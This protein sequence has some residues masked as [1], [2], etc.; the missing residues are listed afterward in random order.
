MVRSITHKTTT[1]TTSA[2]TSAATTTT[3]DPEY[4]LAFYMAPPQKVLLFVCLFCLNSVQNSV[5]SAIEF[6][7][8]IPANVGG[9]SDDANV[10]RAGLPNFSWYNKQKWEKVT[11]MATKIP[12]DQ[13]ITKWPHKYQMATK[14]PN[15]HKI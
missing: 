13:E 10:F 15:G 12:N 4:S 11:K 6:F 7:R 9:C 1:T 8:Q 14:I 5:F 2:T 3:T